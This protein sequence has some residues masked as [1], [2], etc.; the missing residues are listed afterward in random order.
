MP[1]N[2]D[3]VREHPGY[4]RDEVL[5]QGH[6]VEASIGPTEPNRIVIPCEFVCFSEAAETV[7]IGPRGHRI[8]RILD[9]VKR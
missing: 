3:I 1:D 2:R 4:P 8:A 9:Y 5:S 6:S 7:A